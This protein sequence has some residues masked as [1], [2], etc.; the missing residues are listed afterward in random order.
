MSGKQRSGEKGG[1]WYCR[2]CGED[3]VLVDHEDYGEGEE[4]L[5]DLG[6]G[7]VRASDAEGDAFAEEDGEDDY[8][9]DVEGDVS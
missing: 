5:E 8:V 9:E 7:V 3:Y 6:L 2:A 1:F 4:V